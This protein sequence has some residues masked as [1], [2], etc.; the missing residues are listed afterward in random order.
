M[1]EINQALDNLIRL[2]K[3]PTQLALPGHVRCSI[4]QDLKDWKQDVLSR[5]EHPQPTSVEAETEYHDFAEQV[6]A[7]REWFQ[8]S[9]D[10]KRALHHDIYVALVSLVL[11]QSVGAVLT[12]F[13][14]QLATR[15]SDFVRPLLCSPTDVAI[16]KTPLLTLR[17]SHSSL[18]IRAA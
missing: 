12:T 17:S 6:T 15:F 11:L 1:Q 13:L 16:L 7:Y 9:L 10:E 4:D 18:T 3:P 5:L 14:Y 8:Q 2:A